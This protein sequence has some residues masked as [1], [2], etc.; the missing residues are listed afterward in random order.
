MTAPLH[1]REVKGKGRFYGT[2]G[3]DACPF[4]QDEFM[5]VTNAQSVVAKPAL[6]PAAV[7]VTAAAAW[8]RLPSMVPTSRQPVDGPCSKARVA[9][10]YCGAPFAASCAEDC[11]S[12]QTVDREWVLAEI[13]AYEDDRLRDLLDR[14]GWVA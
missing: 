1:A 11:P 2:C 3:Q 10:R 6:V 4:G 12:A 13:D 7:K 5:S 8:D 14:K 9:N